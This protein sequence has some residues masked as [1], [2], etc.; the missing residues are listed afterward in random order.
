MCVCVRSAYTHTQVNLKIALF[1]GSLLIYF[2]FCSKLYGICFSISL[3]PFQIKPYALCARAKHVSVYVHCALRSWH[4]TEVR[5]YG[6]EKPVASIHTYILIFSIVQHISALHNPVTTACVCECVCLSFYRKKWNKTTAAAATAP[7]AAV[8]VATKFVSFYS[9]AMVKLITFVC[10]Y[11]LNN[12]GVNQ[13]QFPTFYWQ[14]CV[15]TL[16]DRMPFVQYDRW[17]TT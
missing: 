3:N 11:A 12:W 1:S 8:A 15:R 9:S 2:G 6:V 16:P 14:L 5:R 10:T 7:V 17:Y 13:W 4:K